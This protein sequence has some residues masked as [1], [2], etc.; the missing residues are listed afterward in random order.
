[1]SDKPN[2]TKGRFNDLRKDELRGLLS[3][4]FNLI[5]W[6]DKTLQNNYIAYSTG[7]GLTLLVN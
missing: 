3:I 1:M 5:V 6:H 7:F 4:I 2:T